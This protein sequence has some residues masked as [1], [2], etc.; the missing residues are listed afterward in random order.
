MGDE[1]DAIIRRL[2]RVSLFTDMLLR[3]LFCYP[4][5]CVFFCFVYPF[6]CDRRGF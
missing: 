4:I 6:R 3:R 2:I 1:R 5:L